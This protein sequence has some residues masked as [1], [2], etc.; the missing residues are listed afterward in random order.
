MKFRIKEVQHGT[1]HAFYPQILTSS[2]PEDMVLNQTTRVDN[3][4]LPNSNEV[5]Y[6]IGDGCTYDFQCVEIIK[7]C[8]L[9]PKERQVKYLDVEFDNNLPMDATTQIDGKFVIG[10]NTRGE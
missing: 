3:E 2:I 1:F 7:K 8:K 4:D 9:F 5:W 10:I 6:N